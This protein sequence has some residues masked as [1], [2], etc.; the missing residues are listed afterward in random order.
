MEEGIS[1]SVSLRASD[2]VIRLGQ[3]KEAMTYASET[4]C[5]LI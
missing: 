2:V 3:L 5:S 4:D 1:F